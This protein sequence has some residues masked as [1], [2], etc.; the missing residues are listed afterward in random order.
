MRKAR[1]VRALAALAALLTLSLTATACGQEA[2]GGSRYKGGNS[3]TIGIAMPVKTSERWIADGK[4][5]VKQ[6]QAAGYKTDLQ[7]GEDDVRTQVAQLENMVTKQYKLLVIAPIDGTALTDVLQSAHDAN[8]PVISYDRLILGSKYVDYYATF[9]NFKVGVLQASYLVKKLGL[10]EGKKG[11]FNI[12]LFAGS[13]DDNNT[14]YFFNG[15]MSVLKPYLADGRLVVRSGQTKLNQLYTAKWS[16]KDAQDRMENLLNKAYSN[17]DVNAV[18]S[19]YDGMSMGILSALQGVGYGTKSKPYPFVSGQDAELPS[20]KSIIRGEQTQTVYK[21]T[22]KL[23]KA[24]VQMATAKLDG[25]KP[26]VNDT[27]SYDNGK[28]VVPAYLLNPV[29]I[30]KSNTQLLVKEGY[31]TAG[32]LK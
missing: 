14:R 30:D 2:V 13:S 20:I 31:Y 29:S 10:T 16:G 25:G 21:D 26:Q 28:K 9:D 19:P 1:A 17:A 5:M 32:Q 8:I 12:E 11:P 23:A 15:A 6:F 24:T 22:R 7:Y 3:N 4:N 18:L 27:K